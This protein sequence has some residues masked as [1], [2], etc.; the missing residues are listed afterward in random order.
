MEQ[1][2]FT[3]P[4]LEPAQGHHY[5]GLQDLAG[6]RIGNRLPDCE[7]AQAVAGRPRDRVEAHIGHIVV[8]GEPVVPW[9]DRPDDIPQ[10]NLL[11][12]RTPFKDTFLG[13][14]TERH[15]DGVVDIDKKLMLSCGAASQAL[16][17]DEADLW[18][19]EL[20]GT[21]VGPLLVAEITDCHKGDI[22]VSNPVIC[23][24]S[25]HGIKRKTKHAKTDS[26]RPICQRHV[27]V[28]R[29]GMHAVALKR[30]PTIADKK[31]VGNEGICQ[32]ENMRRVAVCVDP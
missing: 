2:G 13:G 3:Q 8:M 1:Q 31:A 5:V 4:G 29:E 24:A 30:S 17:L 6:A 32:H 23:R 28:L 26:Q 20:V 9:R 15:R 18:I 14:F 10:P 25:N 21:P 7:G 12:G 19:Q 11:E 22:K 27:N 16:T